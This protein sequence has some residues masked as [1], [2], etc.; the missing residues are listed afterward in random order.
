MQFYTS[1][2]KLF[3]INLLIFPSVP[4]AKKDQYNMP[5]C[6]DIDL[7]KQDQGT[8]FVIHFLMLYEYKCVIL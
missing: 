8:W 1:L 6:R 5:S 2:G 3:I 7:T 4:V